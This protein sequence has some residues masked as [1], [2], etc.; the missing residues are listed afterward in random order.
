[1]FPW[2]QNKSEEESSP[3]AS[4]VR[5]RPQTP[6]LDE[7]KED[8]HG[9]TDE[10]GVDKSLLEP[11]MAQTPPSPQTPSSIAST[12]VDVS[13]E[14]PKV[15]L[16]APLA[17][18]WTDASHSLG[19]RQLMTQWTASTL[20]D[21][22]RLEDY[23]ALPLICVMGDTS[24][25]KSTVLSQLTG[26]AL[27]AHCQLTTKCPTLMQLQPSKEDHADKNTTATVS[28]Q[29]HASSS[30]YAKKSSSFSPRT[31]T[32]WQE[33]PQVILEAQ[34][35]LLQ[36]SGRA[37]TPDRVVVK[38]QGPTCPH[39][40]LVDLPGTVHQA[41]A[42]EAATLPAD[43]DAVL[44]EYWNNPEALFLVVLQSN[45]DF[46]NAAL[47]AQALKKG[48]VDR[49]IPVL[50]KPDLI[51]SGAEKAVCDLLTGQT[52]L[53]PETNNKNGNE[54]SPSLAFHMIK[55][56]GQAALDRQDS[57]LDALSDEELYF[58]TNEPWKSIADRSLLGTSH[59][60]TK[61][62]QRQFTQVKKAISPALKRLRQEHG[63]VVAALDDLGVP[64]TTPAERRRLYQEVCQTFAT[65]LQATL[66]GKGR[67]K[68]KE[69]KTV[70]SIASAAASLHDACR[71]FMQKI[72]EGSLNTIQRVVEGAHVLVT[73]RQGTVR[74]EVVHLDTDFC[75]VDYVEEKDAQSVA[76]FDATQQTSLETMEENDVWSDGTTI[77]IARAN[78]MFDT[79][80]K[81]PLTCVRT[82]PSWLKDHMAQHRTDDLACFLNVDVF[83]NIVQDFIE[84]DWRPHCMSFLDMLREILHTAIHG[85]WQ[86]SL[87]RCNVRHYPA[88]QAF[89]LQEC[90]HVQTKL[91]QHAKQQ[92]EAHLR[93]E[94]HPYT[95]DD[96]LFRNLAAARQQSLRQELE[97]A[98]GLANDVNPPSKS[99]VVTLSTKAISE[100]IDDVF[101]RHE[102]RPV[103]DHL[104]AEMEMVLASYGQIATRRVID[105]TPMIG[106]EVFRSLTASLQE[107]LWSIT[108]DALADCF[109]DDT[110]LV[111]QYDF[112]TSKDKD[113]R[114]AI[115]IF[116]AVPLEPQ[117][118]L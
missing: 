58:M 81:I 37:V 104:A 44:S 75:C 2:Q 29:W 72:G 105:R 112:L 53:L 74:G 100:I 19:Y 73:S 9:R 110:E 108:D 56:R 24:S 70:P 78:H 39:L 95:Q 43:I 97:V 111:R 54:H 25:G 49:T 116:Q 103:E 30:R 96:L 84:E 1:M 94:Q 88:L 23:C 77:Y 80:R 98:L 101:A 89:I 46:H 59:L 118:M 60:R 33:L 99:N 48:A 85:A 92:V 40:T 115:S 114:K 22:F 20:T 26:I 61:L 71:D 52:K 8:D 50:T 16:S 109:R 66:S 83:Q 13:Q 67:V 17:P 62:S 12:E 32:D 91:L 10:A 63:T 86:N 18:L 55:G 90:D 38:V 79:L 6:P 15:P 76:L 11:S 117:R 27:P 93:V 14:L 3:S 106:W 51:D 87:L 113:L 35:F 45:V 65:Q 107:S 68:G 64:V 5:T 42:N 69:T 36:A 21:T 47:L 31:V 7:K 57:L 41:A 34:E 82:D 28:I 102:T 4:A